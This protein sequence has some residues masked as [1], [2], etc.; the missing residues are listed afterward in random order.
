MLPLYRRKVDE[1]SVHL[2]AVSKSRYARGDPRYGIGNP[3]QGH[4]VIC[5]WNDHE[6]CPELPPINPKIIG[7]QH[8]GL[9]C[10]KL[11]KTAIILFRWRRHHP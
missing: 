8:R 5:N 11:T 4:A 7:Q 2:N 9:E 3:Q 6:R 10:C 1:A